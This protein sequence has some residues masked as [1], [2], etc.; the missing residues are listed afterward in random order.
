MKRIDGP[1]H[2]NGLFRERDPNRGLHGTQLTAEWLNNTQEEIVNSIEKSSLTLDENDQTQ[3]FKAV[4]ENVQQ[5]ITGANGI[6]KYRNTLELPLVGHL[7]LNVGN[8]YATMKVAGEDGSAVSVGVSNVAKFTSITGN[9]AIDQY[10]NRNNKIDLPCLTGKGIRISAS[11][12]NLLHYSYD[13]LN[14]AVDG[15]VTKEASILEF[16]GKKSTIIRKL[17]SDSPLVIAPKGRIIVAPDEFYTFAV[18]VK[19]NNNLPSTLRFIRVKF[20]H[21][22]NWS[23]F[24]DVDVD[25]VNRRIISNT[26]KQANVFVIGDNLIITGVGKSSLTPE[27]SGGGSIGIYSLDSTNGHIES[28]TAEG[29][30]DI[31]WMDM[32]MQ[33][34]FNTYTETNGAGASVEADEITVRGANVN[35]LKSQLEFKVTVEYPF[36]LNDVDSHILF[37]YTY[38]SNALMCFFKQNKC[39]LGFSSDINDCVEFNFFPE[40]NTQYDISLIFGNNHT[41]Y[42]LVNRNTLIVANEQLTYPE[43]LTTGSIQFGNMPL[44]PNT[45]VVYMKN[46]SFGYKIN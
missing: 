30:I 27:T 43:N 31:A 26:N 7:G 23:D 46:I 14:H 5:A 39:Y 3:L 17:T 21:S 32:S 19:L 29:H 24:G 38:G 40:P 35:L 45:C 36:K 11:H 25:I 13:L 28:A 42:L 1:Y 34:G 16:G 22:A 2:D 33:N 4:K 20:I 12:T 41:P 6:D 15:T 9:L 44:T 10:L 18:C 8:N 37:A